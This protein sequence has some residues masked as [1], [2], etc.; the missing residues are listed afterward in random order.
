MSIKTNYLEIAKEIDEKSELLKKKVL[1]SPN[2]DIDLPMG[3][4]YY[5]SNSGSD[6]NDGLSENTPWKTT[7][8]LN[9]SEI[10]PG[11]VVLFKR[12]DVWR[13]TSIYCREGVTYSAYGEGNKP[14]FLGSPENGADEK[15]WTLYNKEQNI[16][17]YEKEFCDLGTLLFNE[18]EVAL[19]EIPDFFEGKFYV[20]GTER[21]EEFSVDKHLERDLSFFSECIPN[22]TSEKFHHPKANN[23]GKLYLRCNK[24]NPGKVYNS[25]EFFT[26]PNLFITM[27]NKNIT[28]DNLAIKYTGGHAIS[29][30]DNA[31]NLTVQNCEI[32]WI[33]GSIQ[34][35]SNG[36]ATRFGN[37]VE[38]Y[39]NV[40]NYLVRNNY[41]YQCYDAGVTHQG[42]AH[43][44]NVVFENNLIEHCIYAI[45]YFLRGNED[46]PQLLQKDI[47]FENNILRY[48]GSG[49]GKQRP[50]PYSAAI[51]TNFNA[52]LA[53]NFVI[54][55]NIID[56]CTNY[57]FLIYAAN[58]KS[59]PKMSDNI[60]IFNK[61]A[62]MGRICAGE[63]KF[64][65]I[66]NKEEL[67]LFLKVSNAD[68]YII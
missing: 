67:D 63:K 46:D 30:Y 40:K 39:L 68:L 23:K 24:G 8:K 32:G 18:E 38:V 56:G 28:I 60:V 66:N 19:K 10:L 48:N 27:S 62:E 3:K 41:I 37:G 13:T 21:K 44:E 29:A 53:E 50:D 2:L 22:K 4:T 9:E 33:G 11:S 59:L 16:W 35:Y 34:I 64:F 26:K 65:D 7:Q 55:N 31:D 49:F 45:E 58:E 1:N 57:M 5:V 36:V 47:Y 25:I 52:N 43:Y 51:R 14:L 6:D 42:G 54:K 12:G 61:E 15:K 20:R 17:V